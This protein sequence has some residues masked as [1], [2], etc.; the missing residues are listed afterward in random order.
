MAKQSDLLTNKVP[1]K[2]PTY[3]SRKDAWTIPLPL[4]DKVLTTKEF[5][6]KTKTKYEVPIDPAEP[7]KGS[8]T[9]MIVHINGKED[10][11]GIIQWKKDVESIITGKGISKDFNK[12]ENIAG[13]SDG[14]AAFGRKFSAHSAL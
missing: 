8:F 11:H 4:L 7:T 10:L 1:R 12:N 13:I 9:C 3:A 14:A 5:E 6:A 2:P